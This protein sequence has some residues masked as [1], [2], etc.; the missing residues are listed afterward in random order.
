MYNKKFKYSASYLEYLDSLDKSFYINVLE[1][2]NNEVYVSDAGGTVIYVNPRAMQNYGLE[3]EKLV[4]KNN[5]DVWE[6]MWYPRIID[7]CIA[8]RRAICVLQTYLITGKELVTV[9][10]PVFD[11]NDQVAYVVCVVQEEEQDYDI[12]YKNVDGAGDKK[13]SKSK[14]EFDNEIVSY[15]SSFCSLLIRMQRVA[16]SDVPVMLLGESGTGK[17]LLA[18]YVHKNSLRKDKPFIMI[19]CAAIPEN[20][21]E[22]ELFGYMPYAFTGANPKGKVGLIEMADTGTL[23]LDEIGD[24]APSLQAK[25]LDV[26]ENKRFIPVGGQ[27]VHSVDIRVIT[28]TNQNLEKLVAEKKFREDL[29]WRI[30]ISAITVPPLRERRD[31]ILPLITFFLNKN[32]MKYKKKREISPEAIGVLQAYSWPGNIRQLKNLIELLCI[33]ANGNTITLEDLPDFILETV[34]ERSTA[35]NAFE[36]IIDQVKQSVIQDYYKR[37]PSSRELSKALGF[38]QSKANRLINQYCRA[39]E[40]EEDTTDNDASEVPEDKK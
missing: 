2:C 6:E 20:L 30:N 19:N 25:L 17:S 29:F 23:F 1:H 31:D 18:E 32:N 34:G 15:N 11:K 8:E 13:G 3:P 26:L 10:T 9:A 38:S 35:E 22:S 4:G 28:A 37:Y 39:L 21:L 7:R 5:Y 14:R 40:I 36:A 16:R 27:E 33:M 12:S 24:L